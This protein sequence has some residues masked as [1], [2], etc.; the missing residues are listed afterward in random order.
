[1]VIPFPNVKSC[2]K[3]NIFY[4][5]VNC[6]GN[7]ITN[8]KDK[9]IIFTAMVRCRGVWKEYLQQWRITETFDN[10]DKYKNSKVLI[11]SLKDLGYLVGLNL[12]QSHSK[13]DD[14]LKKIITGMDP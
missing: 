2:A 3:K 8:D 14:E 5:A 11:D 6:H 9:M 7:S 13:T 4:H 12:M 10:F 1:M